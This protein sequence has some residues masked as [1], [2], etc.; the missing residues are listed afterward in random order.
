[1]QKTRITAIGAIAALTLLGGVG[2]T[3]AQSGPAQYSRVIEAPPGV[4]VL[5]LPGAALSP[6][7]AMIDADFPTPATLMQRI[8]RMM[9]EAQRAFAAPSWAARD[10]TIDA[11]WRQM[12]LAGGSVTGMVVT[13]FSNGHGT[14]TQRVTYAGNGAA[15]LVEVSSTGNACAQAGMPAAIPARQAPPA[16]QRTMPRTLQVKNG[17]ARVQMA[18]LGN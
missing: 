1:M 2:A 17:P 14:C 11:A 9:A 10:R 16:P 6:P 8:D 4:M 7:Q 3:F 13:S 18:Q 15:P 12:P 5:V